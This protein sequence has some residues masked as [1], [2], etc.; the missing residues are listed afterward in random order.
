MTD[1]EIVDVWVAS[2]CYKSMYDVYIRERQAHL[3][4]EDKSRNH[5]TNHYREHCSNEKSFKVHGIVFVPVHSLCAWDDHELW[6]HGTENE[7]IEDQPVHQIREEEH[8]KGTQE[9]TVKA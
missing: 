7:P 5:E 6:R 8:S 4:K 3:K 2:T 1:Y 9:D